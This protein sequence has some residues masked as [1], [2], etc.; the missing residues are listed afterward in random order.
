M[1]F[2]ERQNVPFSYLQGKTLVEIEGTK[3]S[4][5]L[6]FKDNCGNVFRMLH[7]ED[8]CENVS[9]DDICGDFSDIIGQEIVLAEESSNSD[10]PRK[11]E[12]GNE[13]YAESFNG[14]FIN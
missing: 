13:E 1:T 3:F 8:C 12:N 2:K 14:H 7:C 9:I 4:S 10:E 6:Y 11:D 5:T